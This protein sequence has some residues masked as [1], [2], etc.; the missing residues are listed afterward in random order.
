MQL[1]LLVVGNVLC[2][3]SRRIPVQY[4]ETK[5]IAFALASHLQTKLFG[6]LAAT[7]IYRVTA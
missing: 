7:F 2:F 1:L 3:L 5:Y 4:A 6:L